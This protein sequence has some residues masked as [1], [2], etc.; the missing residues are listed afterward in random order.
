MLIDLGLDKP[1]LMNVKIAMAQIQDSTH[2]C[3]RF[4]QK[5]STTDDYINITRASRG[6]VLICNFCH[7]MLSMINVF[8]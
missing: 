3:V 4:T 6:Y 7:V 2:D 5:T 1:T 8:G